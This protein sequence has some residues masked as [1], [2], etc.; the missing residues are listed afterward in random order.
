[1]ADSTNK[2]YSRVQ[3]KI[4]KAENWDKATNFIPLKGE[5]IVY[6]DVPLV[7][8]ENEEIPVTLFKIGD[9]QTLVSELDFIYE[10][11]MTYLVTEALRLA[12]AHTNEAIELESSAR[13]GADKILQENIDEKSSV[14]FCVWEAGDQCVFG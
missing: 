1:M 7:I 4:D 2:F 9:G 8:S 12:M 3:H 13:S 11:T 5:I 6:T 14:Q 10:D